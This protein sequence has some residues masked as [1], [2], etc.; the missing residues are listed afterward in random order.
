MNIAL[1]LV[2]CWTF[3]PT[4][5][6]SRG[7]ESEASIVSPAQP[8]TLTKSLLKQHSRSLR[9]SHLDN[10]LQLIRDQNAGIL[11][12]DY[13]AG[14][15]GSRDSGAQMMFAIPAT[16]SAVCEY[17]VRFAKGFDF[18]RGG[19]LPG[20]AGGEATSG[21]ERPTGDGWTARLMWRRNGEAVLYLYHMDQPR[22]YGEDFSLHHRFIPGR[23]HRVR[24]RVTV[25]D[26][27]RT[28][29]R[30]QVWF[31]GH[32]VR[33]EKS[34]RLRSGEKAP[35][36]RFYFSTFFGGSGPEWA[37]TTRQ[38]VDFSPIVVTPLEN[39]SVQQ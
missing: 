28:N 38:T 13:P 1:A 18:V 8:I 39:R 31:D 6:L 35:V 7:D 29:G 16:Q 36:D 20:L 34:L 3:P 4:S 24:Q 33:D 37:P 2:S 19:K 26:G 17:R 5:L 32:L 22:R 25:N 30:I 14:A 9:W 23:W 27:D 10:R 21:K 15:W 12:V 11:R